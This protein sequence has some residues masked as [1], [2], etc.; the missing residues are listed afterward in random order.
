MRCLD[1]GFGPQNRIR[2]PN[3]DS[4]P[5]SG[6]GA[7][8]WIRGPNEGQKETMRVGYLN[9]SKA[10]GAELL[11]ECCEG[12]SGEWEQ[13][14]GNLVGTLRLGTLQ[15][16][17]GNLVLGNLGGTLWGKVVGPLWN[18]VV[19]TLWEPWSKAVGTLGTLGEPCGAKWRNKVV[20]T[21][22][23]F[24]G[25]VVEILWAPWS[26]IVETLGT[27]AGPCGDLVGQSCGNVVEQSCGNLVGTFWEPCACKPWNLVGQSS[28]QEP[29]EPCG[30]L[31]GT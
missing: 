11:K 24:W 19:G 5:E 7:R 29:W 9:V 21:F 18:K 16:P 30:N 25:K 20:G 3:P 17:C 22:G 31:A 27:L 6:F 2:A 26:K 14:C 13:S 8:E 10:K 1:F 4:G 12:A 23:T 28:L 15:R